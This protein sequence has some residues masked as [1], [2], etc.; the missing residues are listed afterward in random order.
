MPIG[1]NVISKFD[2]RG[3]RDA[4]SGLGKLGKGLA[5]VGIA[6]GAAFAAVGAAGAAFVVASA[7]QLMEI[8]KL[9]AQTNAAILSTGSA[10]GKTVDDINKLNASLEK[11]TGVEAEVIQEGQ[12]MLLTFTNITGD[13]FDEATKAALDLSVALGKDMQSAAMLV[14]K[15]LNDP[16]AG[17]GALSK[18][19]I[20]FTEDQ[21]AAIEAMLELNDTAGAQS[22]I[23][24]ELDRQFGGSAE[25]FG[26]TTAGQLAKIAHMFGEIG[27]AVA[28]PFLD[29]FRDA[30]PVISDVLDAFIDSPEFA[31]MLQ[32]L[33]ESLVEMAPSLEELLPDLVEF[34]LRLIPLLITLI[35]V[36]I[37]LVEGLNGSFKFFNDEM[38]RVNELTENA[39]TSFTLL[40]GPFG[41][42]VQAVLAFSK[43]LGGLGM[44]LGMVLGPVQALFFFFQDLDGSIRRVISTFEAFVR[45]VTGQ[46]TDVI[47]FYDLPSRIRPAFPNIPRMAEGGIVMPSPGGSI[48]NVAEAGRPEAIIPLD[49]LGK[50][51]GG[52]GN[53]Y[54]INVTAGV[55]DPAAIGQQIVTY[56]KK[57][58][59][60][61]GPVFVSA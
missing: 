59:R 16:I 47:S 42:L 35:P 24:G 43:F 38:A 27:E 37:P 31:S 13:H 57:F 18:A 28:G 29:V 23:L 45:L 25:A 36:L 1:L 26:E 2:D 14:G 51:G 8:E 46:P 39:F 58:E 3:I 40:L 10:A 19:G 50:M 5:G 41:Y 34:G 21:K 4:T 17:M 22:I 48:V 15:A 6:A 44:N 11:L 61:G 52:G 60:S 12:N 55:G 32:E 49:R 54:T 7:K 56:I 33:A 53:S 30:L 20:Q 9:N